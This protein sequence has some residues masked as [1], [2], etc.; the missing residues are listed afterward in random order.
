M[1]LERSAK[2]NVFRD[3]KK[4]KP[5]VMPAKELVVEVVH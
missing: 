1:S 3:R 5:N 2:K 4:L